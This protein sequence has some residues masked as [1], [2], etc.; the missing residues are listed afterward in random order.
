MFIA[1]H[2]TFENNIDVVTP[3]NSNEIS[4]ARKRKRDVQQ[5]SRTKLKCS[6]A[7]KNTVGLLRKYWAA[8]PKK[9]SIFD[10]REVETTDSCIALRRSGEPF[11]L[12]GH[13]SFTDFADTWNATA[14]MAFDSQATNAKEIRTKMV[15]L[16]KK[17]RAEIDK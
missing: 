1:E 17:A 12:V 9:L 3:V 15:E 4:Q 8:Q 5:V 11:I 10:T 14:F 2:D 13:S 6:F 16:A 7:P